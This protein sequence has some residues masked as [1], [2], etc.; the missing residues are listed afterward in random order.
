[1][2]TIHRAGDRDRADFGWIDSRRTVLS[3]D[4]ATGF[5]PLRLVSDDRFDGGAGFADHLSRDLQVVVC[6]VAGADDRGGRVNKLPPR[7]VTYA[8]AARCSAAL[9]FAASKPR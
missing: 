4:A 2:M 5:G 9:L 8:G 3:G 1:M 6:V 7:G